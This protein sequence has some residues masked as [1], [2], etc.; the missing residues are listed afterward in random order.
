MNKILPKITSN[1]SQLAGVI[2]IVGKA[3]S[4]KTSFQKLLVNEFIDLGYDI[5]FYIQESKQIGFGDSFN[6]DGDNI[7]TIYNKSNLTEIINLVRNSDPTNRVIFIESIDMLNV[8]GNLNGYERIFNIMT[9][10][11]HLST[12]GY[13]VIIGQ[14]IINRYIG[15]DIYSIDTTI[16]TISTVVISLTFNPYQYECV[17][18]VS[19]LQESFNKPKLK[20][21]FVFN[22]VKN[23]FGSTGKINAILSPSKNNI[24]IRIIK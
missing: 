21:N 2:T 10:L 18:I 3:K 6:L 1:I 13:I 20:P 15:N 12:W 19:K 5:D 11:A 23:R 24:G 16:S 17:S 9:S 7:V 4:G 22:K 8:L 14:N